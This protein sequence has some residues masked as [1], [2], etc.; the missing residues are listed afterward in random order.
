M[1]LLDEKPLV[2]SMS[3]ENL[4]FLSCLWNVATFMLNG[5]LSLSM[6][7][8]VAAFAALRLLSILASAV[9]FLHLARITTAHAVTSPR[10]A[11]EIMTIIATVLPSA[12][13]GD[14][15]LFAYVVSA[16]SVDPSGHFG[17]ETPHK[18]VL[19]A[20]WL[21][22]RVLSCPL[23]GIGPVNSLSERSICTKND[24]FENESGM[25]PCSLLCEATNT[26]S[27]RFFSL[28]RAEGIWPSN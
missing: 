21:A 5:S 19:F 22:G 25:F 11:A 16:A 4:S 28:P 24:K 17:S 13:G 7:Q 10:A 20:Y 23:E 18:P 12:Y 15:W 9:A 26:Q 2:G 8:D 27:G 14:T 6:S 3:C 1:R